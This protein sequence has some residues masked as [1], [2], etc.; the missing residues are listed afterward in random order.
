M[1][2]VLSK[3]QVLY[4]WPLLLTAC[5]RSGT[6]GVPLEDHEDVNL[7][8]AGAEAPIDGTGQY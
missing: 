6:E 1:E 2:C 5:H 4:L 8:P 7:Y 3:R